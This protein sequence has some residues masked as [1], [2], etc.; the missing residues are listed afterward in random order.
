M[1]Q[2]TDDTRYAYV[3]GIVRAKEARLLT[4]SHIDRLIAADSSNF[5]TILADTPYGGYE[6]IAT[7]LERAEV[8]LKQFFDQFCQ[9]LE[10]SEFIDWPEQMH[11][12][13]VKL[14]QGA[15]ELLY[16]QDA[17][18]VETWIEV[19]DEV[20]R[21][22]TEK[23]PFVLSTNLDRILCKHLSEIAQ[24]VPFFSSY[25][26]C[27]FDLENIRSFFRARQ[28][29]KSR[30]IFIQVFLSYGSIEEKTFVDNLA[31]QHDLLGKNFFTTPYAHIIDRGSAYIEEHQSFLRLERLCEEMRLGFLLQA[32]RMA[33]G[34]EPLFA[35]YHFK[36][37]EIK[38]VRQVY[39]G[40][41]NAVAPDALKE[42]IPDVW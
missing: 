15:D 34:V 2:G 22:T 1:I 24:F 5:T 6:D 26:K 33:F 31:T 29:E 20:T 23:N 19:L 40:K 18:E 12:L 3:N 39:W 4:R 36:M 21:F 30:E 10:V 11:N 17:T 35:Y 8:E 7:G 37:G 13:K 14:K 41:L 32:R 42:S 27:Y 25:Y 28:F 16:S 38:K 9:T